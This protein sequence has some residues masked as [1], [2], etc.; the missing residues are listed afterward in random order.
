MVYLG[1]RESQRVPLFLS[2]KTVHISAPAVGCVFNFFFDGELT[3]HHSA[4]LTLACSSDITSHHWLR[5]N[6]GNWTS[7]E[8]N[9]INATVGINDTCFQLEIAGTVVL[10]NIAGP[11]VN[12]HKLL[13]NSLLTLN[14]AAKVLLLTNLALTPHT[15]LQLQ[16]R[17]T[18]LVKGIWWKLLST[19]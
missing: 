2:Q 15:L 14:L 18:F 13:R 19:I 7:P 8:V 9:A 1:S 17:G 6:P 5:C 11:E 10:Q 12:F 16:H 4:I 3:S